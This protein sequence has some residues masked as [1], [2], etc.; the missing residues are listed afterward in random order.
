MKAYELFKI[1]ESLL[2]VMD[3]LA[4]AI[5]DVKYIELVEDFVRLMGEGHKKTYVV[6]MLT[7]KYDVA[8]RTVYRIVDK[9]LA[10]VSV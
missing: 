3:G 1:N 2:K 7:D 10:E 6:Q 9:M 8:E 5:A 4:L